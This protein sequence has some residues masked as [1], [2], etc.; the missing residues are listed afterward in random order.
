[1]RQFAD[2]LHY[3]RKDGTNRLT[4]RFDLPREPG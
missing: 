3:E 4:F 2:A 1:M